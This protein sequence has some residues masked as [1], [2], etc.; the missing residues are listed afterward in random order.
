MLQFIIWSA[1]AFRKMTL[2]IL[3]CIIML[4]NGYYLSHEPEV[5]WRIQV[6]FSLDYTLHDYSKLNAY[7]ETFIKI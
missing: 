1:A 4:M 6:S 3:S 2:A 5:P 7:L